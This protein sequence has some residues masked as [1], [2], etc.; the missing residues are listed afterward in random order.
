MR[1]GVRWGGIYFSYG[2]ELVQLNDPENKFR[3]N[4]PSP[5]GEREGVGDNFMDHTAFRLLGIQDLIKEV[6]SLSSVS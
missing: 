4:V 1:V 6:V 5:A 2:L 3:M